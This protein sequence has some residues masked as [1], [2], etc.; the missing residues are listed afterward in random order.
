MTGLRIDLLDAIFGNLKQMPAIEGRAGMR[1]D[2]DGAQ[3][4]PAHGI[5]GAEPVARSKP[6][7]LTVKR[8][9][10]YL[11]DAGEGSVLPEDFSGCSVHVL[12][13]SRLAVARGV[14]IS[15]RI[16]ATAASSIGVRDRDLK[17]APC[18]RPQASRGPAGQCADWSPKQ[19]PG[20]SST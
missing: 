10:T 18:L 15:S 19:A 4:L 5:E 11:I 6:D 12:H 20:P 3:R 13:P 1:G 9:P 16:P 14:T 7:V 2:I 17:T 8:D